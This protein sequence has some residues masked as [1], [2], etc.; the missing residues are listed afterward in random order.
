ITVIKSKSSNNGL[1]L[2]DNEE[3]Q[4][5]Q[6]DNS[7]F[8]YFFSVYSQ[9]RVQARKFLSDSLI[10]KLVE[11]RK[12]VNRNISFSFVDNM[13]YIAIEYP[14]GIFEPNLFRSMLRFAPLR[15]YF[16]AIQLMLG[17]V[18]ELKLNR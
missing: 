15:N 13:M 3:K 9:D 11:F 18:K 4:L 17:I 1:N 2:L 10:K 5:I 7:E 14:E 12:N 6:I 8:N 16:E